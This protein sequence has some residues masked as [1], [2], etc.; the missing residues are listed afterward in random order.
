MLPA[1]LLLQL[2][3]NVGAAPWRWEAHT[4]HWETIG[5]PRGTLLIHGGRYGGRGADVFMS[6]LKDRD[7]PIVV[8][9][10]AGDDS[11]CGP[12]APS[13]APLRERGATNVTILHTRERRVGNSP[14]FVA[15]LRQARA[16]WIAGGQQSR[17]AK[18]YRNTL[19]H[20]E[21][22]GVLERGGIIAGN[23]AGASI[24]GSF[25]YGGHSAGTE[26]FGFLR[27]TAIGQH[28]IRRRRLGGLVRI[29]TAAPELLGIGIDEDTFIVVNGNRFEVFGTSKVAIC[30]PRDPFFTGDHPYRFLFAGDRYDLLTRRVLSERRAEPVSPRE[31]VMPHGWQ[32][33]GPPK[34]TLVLCGSRPT[35]DVM[36]RFLIAAGG[37]K[38]PVV[39]IPTADSSRLHEQNEDCAALKALGAENVTVWHTVDRRRSNSVAF[40]APLRKAQAVWF[41]DGEQWRLGDAYLNSLAHEVLLSV[42]ERGGVIGGAG[43]GARFLAFHMAGDRYGWCR[44]LGFL[45]ATAVHTW[46]PG[47][48]SPEPIEAILKKHAALL[49]IGIGEA[50]ALVVRGNEGE[51]V[52]RGQVAF[53]DATL[54]GWPW[55]GE[56]SF[57][58]L[59]AGDGYDLDRRRPDW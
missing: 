23:S 43:A 41:C 36:K 18:A 15:P 39:V 2:V 50:T 53:F 17:L 32:T 12:D 8:I 37:G 40:T 46:P 26:G 5:P 11:V 54:R 47:N 4:A 52:G 21:L 10:T 20:R 31:P 56:E 9:P 49:G 34:G 57:L 42:L 55:A 24:Q 27:N 38:T 58:L 44:G 19:T 7:A 29:V 16:V 3:P 30:N 14:A 28:Y 1:I 33:L 45:R 25:L 6:L 22:F 51:V 35:T 59:E 48:S 13:A